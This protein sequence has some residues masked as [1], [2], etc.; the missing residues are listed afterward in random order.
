MGRRGFHI[1]LNNGLT[2]GGGV[3]SLKRRPP[4]KPWQAHGTP[5]GRS[6]AESFVMLQAE[7]RIGFSM[8]LDFFFLNL[9][10]SLLPMAVVM[11][12]GLRK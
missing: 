7:S 12:K 4:F 9:S 11:S 10:A 6:D 3:I 1:F 5:H 2:D 8:S